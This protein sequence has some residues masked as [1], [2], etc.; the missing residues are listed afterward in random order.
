MLYLKVVWHHDYPDE[1]VVIFSRIGDDGYE[2]RKV[3][4]YRDGWSEWADE[5]HES[6]TVGLSEVPVDSI[7]EIAAQAEFEPVVISSAQF[8]EIW[9]RAQ[10]P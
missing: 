1:P 5:S 2:V 4:H 8:E 6:D 3:V 7:E 9:R 10:E